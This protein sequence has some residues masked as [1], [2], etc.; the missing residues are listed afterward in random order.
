M[1]QQAGNS[2]ILEIDTRHA[3]RGGSNWLVMTNNFYS[4]L[5]VEV[6]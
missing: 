3:K 2:W 5:R 1:D 6:G 4:I